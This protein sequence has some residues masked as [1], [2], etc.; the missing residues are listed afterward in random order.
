MEILNRFLDNSWNI[1]KGLPLAQHAA[2]AAL[3]QQPDE[4]QNPNPVADH[5]VGPS[6]GTELW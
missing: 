3:K 4:N 1:K 2:P 6:D 5:Q